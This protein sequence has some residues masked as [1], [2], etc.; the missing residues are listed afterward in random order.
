MKPMLK[1]AVFFKGNKEKNKPLMS[2]WHTSYIPTFSE[3]WGKRILL[4]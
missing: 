1:V 3:L 2:E 4:G